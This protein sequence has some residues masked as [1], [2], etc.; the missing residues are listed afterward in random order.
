M[1]ARSFNTL[2]GGRQVFIKNKV[3][4]LKIDWW[5]GEDDVNVP[6]AS[7]ELFLKDY[8]NAKLNRVAKATHGI[9]ANVY[10]SKLL[11]QWNPI[12]K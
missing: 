1:V 12:N 8:P 4:P 10:I 3:N 2:L 6:I 9:D 7:A 11:R 5:H